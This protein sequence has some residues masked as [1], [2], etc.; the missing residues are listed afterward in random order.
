MRVEALIPDAAPVVAARP[1]AGA[2][3][4]AL[5][6]LGAT[7]ARAQNAEDAFGAGTGTLLSAVYDRARAD[8]AL[9]VAT[10]AASRAAQALQSIMNMQI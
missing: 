2:F 3:S 1:D 8:V 6:A 5:D 9:S 7:L 4:S 10:A